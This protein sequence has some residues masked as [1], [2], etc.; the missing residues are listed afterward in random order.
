MRYRFAF[1]ADGSPE[2]LNS[3]D[4]ADDQRARPRT[5]TIEKIAD[6]AYDTLRKHEVALPAEK[7]DEK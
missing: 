6:I 7:T 2:D 1:A 5:G 4:T 3:S